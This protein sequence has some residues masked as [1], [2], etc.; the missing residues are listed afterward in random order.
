VV[1]LD[2]PFGTSHSVTYL[3]SFIWQLTAK[4]GNYIEPCIVGRMNTMEC[5][6]I[7]TLPSLLLFAIL[8]FA[9]RAAHTQPRRE[10]RVDRFLEDR[11][12]L[13]GILAPR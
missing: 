9:E 4:K 3:V 10:I 12:L 8:V 11:K 5:D 6:T 7:D 2:L 13:T 1:L